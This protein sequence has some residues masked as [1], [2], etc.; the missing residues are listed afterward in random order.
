[1]DFLRRVA[2]IR[3]QVRI[4]RSQLVFAEPKGGKPRDIPLPDT[5]ALAL[6]AHLEQHPARP[7][8]LPWGEPGGKLVTASL[9]LTSST[10][11]AV[12]RNTFNTYTWKPA[13][14]AAGITA[15]RE[16]GCHMLRHTFASVLLYGVD[17]RALSEYLGHTDPGFTLRVYSHLM[18]GAADRMR[19]AIDTARSQ[20]HGPVTAR[21]AAR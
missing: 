7:V 6:A 18:P 4:V 15:D 16:N 14:Q 13:L 8:E 2:H 3:R 9:M 20:D 11:L 1:V 10:G 19:Q 17:I 12:N 5:V 21:G